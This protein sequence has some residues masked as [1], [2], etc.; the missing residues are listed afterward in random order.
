MLCKASTPSRYNQLYPTLKQ[1]PLEGSLSKLRE[2]RGSPTKVDFMKEEM[3]MGRDVERAKE[4][5]AKEEEFNL[6]DGFR[7]ID[8]DGKGYANVED[9]RKGLNSLE[10]YPSDLELSLF[11]HRYSKPSSPSLLSFPSFCDAFT[12]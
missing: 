4:E 12:P 11:L 2:A 1:S 9:L 3:E 6:F 7:V 10:V 8:W 5:L